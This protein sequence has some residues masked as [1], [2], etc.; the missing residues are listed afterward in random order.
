MELQ[1]RSTAQHDVDHRPVDA[2]RLLRARQRPRIRPTSVG[3]RCC[4][5]I[6]LGRRRRTGSLL[7]VRRAHHSVGRLASYRFTRRRD[8]REPHLAH[9]DPTPAGL[10]RPRTSRSLA[11]PGNHRSQ[12]TS[13][14]R[15]PR[16]RDAAIARR[17][18]GCSLGHQHPRVVLVEP[19]LRRCS[20]EKSR[21]GGDGVEV[22]G[23][24]PRIST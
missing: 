24:C 5:P 13:S 23:R 19:S 1:L 22:D 4:S 14:P 21:R 9:R 10:V 7:D 8:R 20:P 15:H 17:R 16:L 18:H 3:Q 2:G 11:H 6:L 12:A